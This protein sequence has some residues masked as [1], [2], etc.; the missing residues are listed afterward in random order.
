MGG[1]SLQQKPLTLPSESEK[2]IFQAKSTLQ[3]QQQ[4]QQQQQKIFKKK[5]DVSIARQPLGGRVQYNLKSWKKLTK[6]PFILQCLVGCKINF[7]SVPFQLSIPHQINFK[8]SQMTILSG[9]IEELLVDRVIEECTTFE[10]GEYMNSV[11]LV[12]KRDS[13]PES[14]KYRLILNMKALNKNFVEMIHHKMHSL[15]TCID[16]MEQ[17]CFMGSI[18]L[19]SAFHSIPMDPEFTKYLKFQVNGKVFKYLVLPMAHGVP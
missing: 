2:T 13:V 15:T 14:P 5:I 7:T 9:L 4:Q 10:E 3:Q 18:D 19:K 1:Q 11:F 16:L 6:D 17:G 8:S 12:E